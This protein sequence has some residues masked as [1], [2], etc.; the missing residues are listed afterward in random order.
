MVYVI[1]ANGFETIEALA[2]V[3][4]LRRAGADVKTVGLTGE[5]IETSHK[6]TVKTDITIGEILL[7][8]NLEMVV[9]PGGMP[10]T[11][12]LED[13]LEVRSTVEFCAENDRFVGAICAAPSIPGHMGLLDGKNFTCFPSFEEGIDNAN[14]TGEPVTVDGKFITA[15]GAG[16]CVPFA[17]KLVEM[18]M[19]KQKA[20]EVAKSMQYNG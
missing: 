20:D 7:D 10:G 18:L 11:L 2:P 5:Y 6:V 17:I 8:D 1:L 12:N 14:Y 16:C 3:D 19:G 9:L 15:K 4:A 13:S